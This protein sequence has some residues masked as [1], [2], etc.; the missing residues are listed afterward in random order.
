MSVRRFVPVRAVVATLVAGLAASPLTACA[1][2]GEAPQLDP[3]SDQVASVGQQLVLV[4]SATDADG[5]TLSYSYDT[6]VPDIDS[7]AELTLRPDGA[8]VF[9]WRPLAQDV[10]EWFFDFTV[11]DGGQTDTITVRIEVRSAVGDSGAPIFREPLGTGTT[12]DLEVRDCLSLNVVVEDPDSSSVVIDQQE[13]RI[14]GATL[15]S[16]GGLSATW[17]WCPSQRQIDETD[18]YMLVLSADD[19]SSPV[20]VK[21]YLIV[22]RSPTKPDC[23]GQP[24]VITHTATDVSSGVGLTIDAQISDDLGLKGEPLLYYKTTPPSTPPDLGTMTQ[25]TMAMVSGNQQ[26]GTWRA[27][28]PNPV[29]GMPAGTS[30]QLYYAIV[31][32]DNDDVEGNCDHVTQAP[33]TGTYQMTVTNPGGAGGAGVCEPCT[34]DVQCGD[35]DD[36]CVRVGPMLDSFCL[37]SCSS[38]TECPTDYHC[39]AS[40]VTSID[41]ASGRQCVPNSEN[42]ADPGGGTTCTDD[43][44]EDNDSRAQATSNPIILPGTFSSLVSC[45]SDVAGDDEDWFRIIIPDDLQ[46][47]L[48][49]A[50]TSASDLD[51]ALYDSTGSFITSSASLSSNESI[52]RCVAPGTYFVRVYAFSPV[53][54][55]YTLTYAEDDT[56]CGT[57]PPMCEDDPA[58][59]DDNEGQA[60]YTEI[61]PDPF[62]DTT[63]AICAGDEDWFEIEAYTGEIVQVDLTFTDA[64][65]DLDLKFLAGGV[66][67]C[68][69]TEC[70]SSTDNESFQYTVPASCSPCTYYVVVH[71]FSG[72]EN[73]YD[74][75]IGLVS[76]P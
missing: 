64:D 66:D 58:E 15:T 52:V 35:A 30:A 21:H 17:Q 44:Y 56:L 38:D 68:T 55:P 42:C 36:L 67:Q 16:T 53:Q 60:V 40:P 69:T 22:L 47:T 49:V 51:L 29:A 10:G 62:V 61:F 7:R 26:S 34:A 2:G 18:R 12:L 39:S 70:R 73:L 11:D 27:S 1:P 19:R 9:K 5:D 6:D 13:P 75:S 33:A 45:P 76:S 63:R 50:G 41:G 37:R 57:P 48:T 23:P 31:A 25:V 3:I 20:T 74:I 65:G 72:A 28:V 71:G 24:P 32:N 43:A 14:D 8:G 46:L 4:I 54:N 59:D